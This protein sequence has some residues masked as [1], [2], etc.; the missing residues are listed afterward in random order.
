MLRIEAKQT[1]HPEDLARE[2]A[3]EGEGLLVLGMLAASWMIAIA[4]IW[5]A[6]RMAPL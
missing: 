5:V 1:E 3:F 6:W 2:N 4:L